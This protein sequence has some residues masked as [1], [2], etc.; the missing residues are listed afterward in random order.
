MEMNKWRGSVLALVLLLFACL[1][2]WAAEKE[3][4]S[5]WQTA[6]ELLEAVEKAGVQVTQLELRAVIMGDKLPDTEYLS[7]QAVRWSRLL[8]L[9]PPDGAQ[10][11]NGMS[12]Y[13]TLGMF[14]GAKLH[15]RFTGVPEHSGYRTY[16]V[17]TLTGGP[18]ERLDLEMLFQK[19]T[20]VLAEESVIPQFSTCIRGK[21]NDT[22][23]VDQQ[24][25]KVFAVLQYLRA[26]EVERL[27]DE[28]VLSV[29][30]FTGQ[31]QHAIQTGPHKMNLQVAAHV[32]AAGKT[33]RITVGTPIITAEY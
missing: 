25:G 1:P 16:L 19:V 12:V 23:S 9:Q 10:Q 20:K 28:T 29:S 14:G 33:T 21:Y 5:T 6:V 31:W 18:S 22:L 2:V 32:D 3:S 11:E 30:A 4:A 15:L 7:K 26:E 24:E 8:G 27:R 13:E 17:L